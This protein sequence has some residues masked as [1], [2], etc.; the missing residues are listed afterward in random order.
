VVGGHI[1][2]V[3]HA[4]RIARSVPVPDV[5]RLRSLRKRTNP[6]WVSQ[7]YARSTRSTSRRPQVL[8]FAAFVASS[9]DSRDGKDS[10]KCRQRLDWKDAIELMSV[11]TTRTDRYEC[12]RD[13]NHRSIIVPLT[14]MVMPASNPKS[15]PVSVD[16]RS[17]WRRA[18]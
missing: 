4:S 2:V 7:Q 12:N 10:R 8:N 15:Y 1:M 16:A 17:S 9:R 14:F 18:M 6:A 3:P 13:S 5:G 11:T